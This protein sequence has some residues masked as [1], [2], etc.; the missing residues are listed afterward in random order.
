MTSGLVQHDPTINGPG[1]DLVCF[2]DH[3][4][5]QLFA[6]VRGTDLS[7]NPWTTH[8]VAWCRSMHG[9]ECKQDMFHVFL[10]RLKKPLIS[11]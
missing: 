5:K 9:G 10:K 11:G 7:L 4:Q 6:A 1:L 2:L 8:E 3:Q